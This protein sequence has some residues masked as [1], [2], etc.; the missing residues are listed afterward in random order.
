MRLDLD[1][2]AGDYPA[3]LQAID[4]LRAVQ[5]K[6]AAK[7]LSGLLA[8][9]MVRSAMEAHAESGEAFLAAFGRHYAESVNP[10]PWET[11]HDGIRR[12]H[13]EA[14]TYTPSMILA[15]VMTELDPAV[16]ASR[17]LDAH[18]AWALV[19]ARLDLR[20]VIS[21]GPS[22]ARV[23][24]RYIAA[25]RAPTPDIWAAREVTLSPSQ[26]LTPVIV[27]IWDSGIDLNVFPGQVFTDPTPTASGNHGLAFDDLGAPSDS[28]LYPL[29]R[30][31]QAAYPEFRELRQGQLD[32]EAG[33]D[34]P[35]ARRFVRKCTTLAPGELAAFQDH[36][37]A[38]LLFARHPLRRDRRAGQPGGAPRRGPF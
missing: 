23:L 26:K 13:V 33:I 11:V 10:L 28:W 17:A 35:A 24:E 6:P 25:H 36:Q 8:R 12:S 16:R 27:A 34:S 1:E 21:V 4:R 29:T 2:L 37:G 20:W 7:L 19:D 22:Q 38:R 9:A 30:A 15:A 31:Q 5:D 18:E 32:I 14:R 3:A